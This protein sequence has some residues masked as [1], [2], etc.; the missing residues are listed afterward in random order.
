M[1]SIQRQ[2]QPLNPKIG[3][4]VNFIQRQIHP[5]NLQVR[6]SMNSIQRPIQPTN[7]IQ[8]HLHSKT[9]QT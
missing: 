9:D 6:F 7:R 3:F 4:N 8:C 2:I 1:N 5:L